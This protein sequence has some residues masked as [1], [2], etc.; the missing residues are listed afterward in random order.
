M[1]ACVCTGYNHV[2]KVVN[3][4]ENCPG[5]PAVL[6]DTRYMAQMDLNKFSEV[7]NSFF[8]FVSSTSSKTLLR[9]LALN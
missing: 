6:N 8:S 7:A 2:A 1:F 9:F 3:H 4:A 5:L